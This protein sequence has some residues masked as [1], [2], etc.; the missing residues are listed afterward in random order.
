MQRAGGIIE[1]KINLKIMT[2]FI[3]SIFV[4]VLLL[5]LVACGGGSGSSA[6]T[7]SSST[8]NSSNIAPVASFTISSTT[9]IIGQAVVFDPKASYDSDG[10][11]SSYQW[12]F[13][14][15]QTL[16]ATTNTAVTHSYA[17]IGSY[18]VSLSVFDNGGKTNSTSLQVTTGL[19][20][21]VAPVASFTT[22]MTT[23]VV[24]QTV[25]FNPSASSDSDGVITAYAWNFGDGS[26]V[27]NATNANVTHAF[28]SVG[29]FNVSLT[30]TDNR[31]G[32]TAITSVI[33]ASRALT[34]T[35]QSLCF[36]AASSNLATCT[37]TGED[38]EFGRDAVVSTNSNDDGAFG[39]SY[40]KLDSTG[41]VLPAS[42][43]SW[44][45]VQ[46]NL[47]GLVWENKVA[48]NSAM[49]S[50]SHLYTWYSTDNS[51]N[52]GN[53]GSTGSNTCNAT[54]TGGL[55]NTQAYVQQVNALG[56]CGKNDWR[57][58][59]AD[60]LL[61]TIHFG[62]SNPAI[63][64]VFFSLIQSAPYWTAVVNP[65]LVTQAI[66]I[67]HGV[68]AITPLAKSATAAIRLVRGRQ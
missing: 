29:T 27:T 7:N 36:D 26:V 59:M 45:C 39:L 63:D 57:L 55:C 11:I 6:S 32:V 12:D 58:P 1:T 35:G 4:N 38:G 30:V 65:A 67:D 66:S 24:A 64:T 31:G 33:K 8:A 3:S 48:S 15:G 56:L 62:M 47:T 49:R 44:D 2:K 20:T 9:P 5:T 28:A 40:T 46:D 50:S 14:D 61:S 19:V 68:F 23:P 18:T 43:T 22:S 34:D 17:A 60:E 21:N 51:V 54:L 25:T 16:V 53:V 10:S 37:A 41:S 13:G 42:A 52:G